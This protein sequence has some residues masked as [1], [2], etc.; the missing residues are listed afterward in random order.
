MKLRPVKDQVVVQMIEPKTE[1]ESGLVIPE[2]AREQGSQAVVMAVGPYAFRE[3]DQPYGREP[4][5]KAGDVVLLA[6]AGCGRELKVDGEVITVVSA[7]DIIAVV[8]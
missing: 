3:P 1:T 7:D 8:E 5:F 6:H 4:D 2:G